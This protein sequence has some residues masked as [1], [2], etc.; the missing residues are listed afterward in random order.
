MQNSKKM[1]NTTMPKT[2]DELREIE[3]SAQMM[4][5][6]STPSQRS[7]AD[8]SCDSMYIEDD[9]SR[10]A[11]SFNGSS[12]MSWQSSTATMEQMKN[13]A[14]SGGPRRNSVLMTPSGMAGLADV[15]FDDSDDD[16][17]GPPKA[18]PVGGT[19]NP[20]SRPMVGGFAAAAYEAARADYYKK[21][22]EKKSSA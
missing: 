17:S 12:E 9:S 13:T 16:D 15:D 5:R 7:F 21:Q 10:Y 20:N 6:G 14:P 18:T 4:G 11:D 8:S 3:K 1:Q 19:G 2:K 22:Q